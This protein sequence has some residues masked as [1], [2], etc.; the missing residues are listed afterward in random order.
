MDDSTHVEP[1]GPTG[2][3]DLV[4]LT[5]RASDLWRWAGRPTED[6]LRS[7]AGV[8]RTAS[9]SVSEALPA[10]ILARV[11]GADRVA[12]EAAEPFIVACLRCG[13]R[14]QDQI[15]FELASWRTAWTAAEATSS[16]PAA[17]H[18]PHPG[19]EPPAAPASYATPAQPPAPPAVE[20]WTTSHSETTSRSRRVP[21]RVVTL[22]VAASVAALVAV[23]VTVTAS[24]HDP[25]AAAL[26][27]TATETTPALPPDVALPA[28]APT[29]SQVTQTH[30][31]PTPS[32][33]PPAHQT[34]HGGPTRT[35]GA[36]PASTPTANVPPPRPSGAASSAPA[37]TRARSSSTGT[38]PAPSR[39]TTPPPQP[40][41]SVCTS[42]GCAAR[43]YFVA[44]GEHL[45][46]C[47]QTPDGYGAVAQY[48]RTDVPGQNNVAWNRNGS[49]TCVD[50][51]MNMPEGAKI[52]FRVCLGDKSGRLSRC[53]AY[54]T[55]VA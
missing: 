18:D 52:R 27:S 1:P 51:N 19:D 26:A 2:A 43:A 4:E 23:G 45:F 44:E 40:N 37:A 13:R 38:A 55:A 7:L 5:R 50:H 48:T 21:V 20:P 42:G 53:S 24:H 14:P 30:V 28:R 3:S 39:T 25:H 11:L 22:G 34:A 6:T 29:P 10:G 54:I 32:T 41:A 8:R 15:A 31:G 9:G 17:R 16:V 46:V 33:T 35:D 36:S 49:G 47:D 12:W